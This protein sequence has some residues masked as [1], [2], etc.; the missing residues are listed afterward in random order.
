[1]FMIFWGRT[2]LQATP[3]PLTSLRGVPGKM[4]RLSILLY[5]MYENGTLSNPHLF[6]SDCQRSVVKATAR[7]YYSNV[8]K[9][10]INHSSNKYLYLCLVPVNYLSMNDHDL[11]NCDL[12]TAKSA[13]NMGHVPVLFITCLQDGNFLLKNDLNLWILD[14]V[15]YPPPTH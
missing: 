7:E 1:M 3:W 4:H 10:S 8:T 11:P 5:I 6:I 14:I 13:E 15:S 2:F 12:Y 9:S